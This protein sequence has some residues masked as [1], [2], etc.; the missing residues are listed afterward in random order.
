MLSFFEKTLKNILLYQKKFT[1]L[2]NENK[3]NLFILI[4]QF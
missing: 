1:T 3:H 4:N 2:E